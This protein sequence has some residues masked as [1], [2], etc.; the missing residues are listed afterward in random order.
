MEIQ[1]DIRTVKHI[2]IKVPHNI[3]DLFT[4]EEWE[5][6]YRTHIHYGTYHLHQ[7]LEDMEELDYDL[8]QEEKEFIEKVYKFCEQAFLETNIDVEIE[9]LDEDF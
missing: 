1:A 3:Y 7:L 2:D 6:G 8:E 5:S 9:F 4:Y